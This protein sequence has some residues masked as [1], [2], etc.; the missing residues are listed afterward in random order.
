[1]ETKVKSDILLFGHS[2]GGL[3]AV[4]VLLNI[5]RSMELKQKRNCFGPVYKTYDVE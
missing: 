5:S 3:L 1:M 4:F 2:K